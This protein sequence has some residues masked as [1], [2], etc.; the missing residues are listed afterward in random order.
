MGNLSAKLVNGAATVPV[1]ISES[2]YYDNVDVRLQATVT[3]DVDGD[4]RPDTVVLLECSP[5]PSN[6]SA[7]EVHVFRAE[8]A[9]LAVLPSPGSLPQTTILAPLYDPSGLTVQHG[10]VVAVMKAY[11][12]N[13]SHATGPS[14][15]FTV[16]WHW[17][18]KGF[19]PLP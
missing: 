12:P 17:A 6:G 3:G 18:G 4:G 19:A 7:Q 2:P 9:E 10:D 11:G 5:Q 13:D 14:V 1:D 15:P 8:G 16:R